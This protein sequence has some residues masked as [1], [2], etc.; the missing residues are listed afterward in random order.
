MM[1]DNAQTI[2]HDKPSWQSE[3]W[4]NKSNTDWKN[5]ARN[6]KDFLFFIVIILFFLNVKY[7][8]CYRTSTKKMLW[9][10]LG[11]KESESWPSKQKYPLY[12]VSPIDV[13]LQI[14]VLGVK[15]TVIEGVKGDEIGKMSQWY[16]VTK[17]LQSLG[18]HET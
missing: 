5:G 9:L 10:Y 15:T 13:N 8:W 17:D 7:S 3:T 12:F 2:V 11:A 6:Q 18:A 16:E 14:P 1:P 4:P